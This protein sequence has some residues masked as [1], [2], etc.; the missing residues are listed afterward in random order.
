[1]TT[2]RCTT[3]PRR[4]GAGSSPATAMRWPAT[5]P[6]WKQQVRAA[7]PGVTLRLVSTVGNRIDFNESVTLDVDVALN[8]LSPGDVRLECVVS[9]ELCSDLTVPVR[10]YAERGG[11]ESGPAAGGR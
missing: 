1:M 2:R 6:R 5:W 3:G 10:Q 4:A 11:S 7:W 8:G 9:R